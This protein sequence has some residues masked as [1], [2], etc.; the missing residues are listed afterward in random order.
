MFFRI[1]PPELR[2]FEKTYLRFFEKTYFMEQPS[3]DA[4]VTKEKICNIVVAHGGLNARTG[5]W[6]ADKARKK[7]GVPH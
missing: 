7:S 2:S 6:V 1:W 5:F 3:G 4:G